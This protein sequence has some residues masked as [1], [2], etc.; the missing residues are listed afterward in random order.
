[1]HLTRLALFVNR[2]FYNQIFLAF[3]S[4]SRQV[5]SVVATT[6]TSANVVE[7]NKIT[8]DERENEDQSKTGW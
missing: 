4:I 6:V 2:T 1:M 8:K 5:V 3:Y 7:Q